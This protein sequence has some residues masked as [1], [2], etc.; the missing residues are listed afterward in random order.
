MSR[1]LPGGSDRCGD[2]SFAGPG[3]RGTPPRAGAVVRPGQNRL[4]VGY[5]YAE[6][7]LN[8]NP[9]PN[10]GGITPPGGFPAVRYSQALLT[11]ANPHRI[12]FG[13]GRTVLPGLDIDLMAGGM[14]RSTD[15]LGPDTSVTL[16]SYWVGFGLTWRFG[17]G[18]CCPPPAP[19][20]WGCGF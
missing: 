17:R 14:L 16:T 19:D 3:A 15:E 8:P 13:I 2:R 10:L 18:A 20:T 1:R 9:G 7:P 12:S 4:R 11:I 6:N 5:A